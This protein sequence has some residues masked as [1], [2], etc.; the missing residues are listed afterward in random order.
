MKFITNIINRLFGKRFEYLY[1][2][3]GNR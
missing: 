2:K 1:T 3:R